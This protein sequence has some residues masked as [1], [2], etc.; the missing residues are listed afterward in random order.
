[1]AG[2]GRDGP[3]GQHPPRKAKSVL[4]KQQSPTHRLAA[5]LF[6]EAKVPY[7]PSELEQRA[8]GSGDAQV[9]TLGCKPGA[10]MFKVLW[11]TADANDGR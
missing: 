9:H 10:K 2:I 1:M 11:P 6:G 8:F 7:E 4:A 3:S 5:H